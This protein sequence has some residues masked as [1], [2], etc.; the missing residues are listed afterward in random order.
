MTPLAAI[1]YFG[2][3]I[4]IMFPMNDDCKGP[5]AEIQMSGNLQEEKM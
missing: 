5:K 4:A 2:K 1:I 3:S